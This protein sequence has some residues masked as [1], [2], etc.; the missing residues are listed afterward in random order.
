[1]VYSCKQCNSKFRQ[2]TQEKPKQ[3][4]HEGVKYL[5]YECDYQSTSQR[6]LKRSLT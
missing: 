3:S 4:E 1:V 5:C 2:E 6:N